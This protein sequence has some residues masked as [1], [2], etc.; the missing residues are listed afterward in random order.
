METYAHRIYD[1]SIGRRTTGHELKP[2]LL[3]LQE[4]GHGESQ[5]GG[6]GCNRRGEGAGVTEEVQ[7]S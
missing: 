3:L 4:Q 5:E 7:V 6:P 2:S 1:A